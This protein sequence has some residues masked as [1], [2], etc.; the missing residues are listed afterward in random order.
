MVEL[1]GESG[2]IKCYIKNT[3]GLPGN[4]DTWSDQ[5]LYEANGILDGLEIYQS[6]DIGYGLRAR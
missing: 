1:T 4:P 5:P 6:S 3:L 2:N